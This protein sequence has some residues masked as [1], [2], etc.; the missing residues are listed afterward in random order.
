MRTGQCITESV[1]RPQNINSERFEGEQLE[2]ALV[3][4]LK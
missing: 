1:H 4:G 2:T 3:E